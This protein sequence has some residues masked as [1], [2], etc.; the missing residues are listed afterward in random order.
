MSGV[1]SQES[2]RGSGEGVGANI[3]PSPRLRRASEHRTLNIQR[4][5]RGLFPWLLVVGYWLLGVAP[6]AWGGEPVRLTCEPRSLSGVPGE[7]LAVELT[8]VSDRAVP[9]NLHV[10]AVSNLV[11]CTVER[12]PIQRAEDGRYVQKRIVLWQGVEAG[13]SPVTN[14]CADMAGATNRFPSIDVTITAV[15]PAAPPPPPKEDAE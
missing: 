8:A 4:R 9:L 12:V 3:P 15:E 1:R 2:W 13:S 5:S 10:P 6:A 11:L 7:P 14:L